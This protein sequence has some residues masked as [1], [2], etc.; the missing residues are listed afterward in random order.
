MPLPT[1]VI[2]LGATVT[3]DLPQHFWGKAFMNQMQVK[4]L[5]NVLGPTFPPS[6]PKL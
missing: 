3:E 4:A 1:A 5:T 6:Q 2:D